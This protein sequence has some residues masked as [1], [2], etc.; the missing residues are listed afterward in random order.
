MKT[1]TKISRPETLPG[2]TM[3]TETML[4]LCNFK[5]KKTTNVVLKQ[6]DII[7]KTN[8]PASSLSVNPHRLQS[9]VSHRLQSHDSQFIMSGSSTKKKS[10]RP[11]TLTG[12]SM[13]KK[14]PLSGM[15]TKTKTK[16]EKLQGDTG[17]RRISLKFSN[18]IASRTPSSKSFSKQ[19]RLRRRCGLW[20]I[21]EDSAESQS[22]CPDY[23][24]FSAAHRRQ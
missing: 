11:K 5:K 18:K 8:P 3:Q 4:W 15:T 22:A 13:A 10:S 24:R 17:L 2:A 9:N 20:K 7:K 23:R 21:R 12:T 6:R 16:K 19:H 1:T 14:I